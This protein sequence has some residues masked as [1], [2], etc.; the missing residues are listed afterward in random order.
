[1]DGVSG[2]KDVGITQVRGVAQRSAALG[3]ENG[4]RC[5]QK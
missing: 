1:M 2:F 3:S 5:Q 4:R